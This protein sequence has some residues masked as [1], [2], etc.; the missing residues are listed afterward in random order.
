MLLPEGIEHILD[1]LDPPPPEEA[2]KN[3]KPV[4]LR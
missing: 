3:P 2:E 1:E 4:L